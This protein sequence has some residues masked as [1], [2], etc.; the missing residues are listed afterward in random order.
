[1]FN[2][3]E[4][5]DDGQFTTDGCFGDFAANEAEMILNFVPLKL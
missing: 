2:R 4:E 5:F 3:L 1:M